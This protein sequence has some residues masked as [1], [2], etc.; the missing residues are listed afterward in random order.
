MR[1]LCIV[2]AC[3]PPGLFLPNTDQGCAWPSHTRDVQTVRE[4]PNN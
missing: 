3:S 2:L 4:R 1:T